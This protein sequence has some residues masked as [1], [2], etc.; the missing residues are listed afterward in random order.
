MIL[1]LYFAGDVRG[2][3][4]DAIELGF[5]PKDTDVDN[6]QVGDKF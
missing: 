1:Y 2:L 6:L 3:V 4:V 5:L